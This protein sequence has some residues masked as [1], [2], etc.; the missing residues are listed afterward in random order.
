MAAGFEIRNPTNEDMEILDTYELTSQLLWYTQD[1][2]H[3]KNDK[4]HQLSHGVEP[5]KNWIVTS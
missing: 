4:E 1:N 3:E 5:I 2:R